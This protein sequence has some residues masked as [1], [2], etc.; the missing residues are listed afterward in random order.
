MNNHTSLNKNQTPLIRLPEVKVLASHN[1]ITIGAAT[2]E[3]EVSTVLTNHNQISNAQTETASFLQFINPSIKQ[4][5]P[6]VI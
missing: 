1:Q 2:D 4:L 3:C 6:F 5:Y